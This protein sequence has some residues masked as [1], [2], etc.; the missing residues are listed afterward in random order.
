L[1]IGKGLTNYKWKFCLKLEVYQG[2]YKDFAKRSKFHQE[3]IKNLPRG[4]SLTQ[5]INE[6]AKM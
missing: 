1:P 3:I 2:K 5:K 6:I 4:R